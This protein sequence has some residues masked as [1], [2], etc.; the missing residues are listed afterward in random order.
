MAE[1]RGETLASRYHL[2]RPLGSG[3]MGTVW[4]AR[5]AMLDREVAVKELRIPDG[6]ADAERAELTARV[7]REAEVTAR[8]RHPGIVAVHD[9]LVQGGRPWIVMELLHGRDLAQE[10]SARGPLPPPPVADLGARVLEALMATHARG[11]QHRD[12]KPGNVFI[13]GDGRVVLTDFGI[14]RPADQTALTEA[15]LL[16]G[17]PGFIAPE[18]LA[19]EPGGPASDLWSF[20]A[21]LYAAV[22]GV[23]PYQG[24]QAEVIRATLTRECRPPRLAG[25]LGPL[26]VW[27]LARDPL[28]RPDAATALGHLRQI[29]EGGSPEIRPRPAR[30]VGRAGSRTP[31]GSAGRTRWW[32]P[33]V[34][35]AVAVAALGASA[36]VL[37]PKS[38]EEGSAQRT[39]PGSPTFTHAVDLCR[40]LAAPEVARLLGTAKPPR[41]RSR[42]AECQWTIDGA[43]LGL[44]AVTDSDTP[45]PWS[46]TAESARTLLAGY[47]RQYGSGPR[48]GEWI[49]YEIGL[50]RKS[51]VIESVAQP[52]PDVADQAFASDLSTP[53]GQ[54]QGSVVFFRLG[55]LVASLRYADLD[56]TS[57]TD[58]RRRAVEAA[59][60]A[61]DGLRGLA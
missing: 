32:V 23:P 37:L 54:V 57:P 24:S 6:V 46:L 13:T 52:V 35:V 43:G 9:V 42:E 19:G 40:S 10:I 34:A 28:A 53:E 59:R 26:L 17:S 11:V 51:P 31:A 48:D 55:D 22:E 20:A 39:N 12:V 58:V 50:D 14:A 36:M 44:T 29:A 30:T 60:S 38:R 18:R 7:M 45:D 1:S 61:A 2:L 25:P 49:W 21:T 3:G 15:G 56:A 5:D 16:V 41:G 8:L 47:Q 33:A 4:L 27:M